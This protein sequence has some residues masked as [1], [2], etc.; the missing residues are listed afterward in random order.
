MRQCFLKNKHT[1]TRLKSSKFNH[2]NPR[3]SFQFD[4]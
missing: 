2:E 4:R 1:L 3:N